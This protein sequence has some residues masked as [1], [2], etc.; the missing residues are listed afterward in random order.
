M[1]TS[2]GDIL[3]KTIVALVN[4]IQLHR[5]VEK[6]LLLRGW[7]IQGHDTQ[8]LRMNVMQCKISPNFLGIFPG[9]LDFSIILSIRNGY[10]QIKK[11]KVR[12]LFVPNI[13]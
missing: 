1:T 9:K 6:L 2:T 7:L 3:I 11:K 5:C 13:F 12:C 10:F 4:F 8:R